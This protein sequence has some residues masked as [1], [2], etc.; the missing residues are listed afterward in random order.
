M[1]SKFV[2]L[3]CLDDMKV[4]KDEVGKKV[5][6]EESQ[7]TLNIVELWGALIFQTLPR[8]E[9]IRYIASTTVLRRQHLNIANPLWQNTV[10]IESD[11]HNMSRK[12]V[13][14][15]LIKGAD[16]TTRQYY[17]ALR[18][19][20]FN[21]QDSSDPVAR[22]YYQTR[23]E[24]PHQNLA[25]VHA[26][27]SAQVL[28]EMLNGREKV[29][30]VASEKDIPVI[31]FGSFRFRLARRKYPEVLTTREVF[32]QVFLEEGSASECYAID[33]TSSDPARRLSLRITGKVNERVFV[34]FV[35]AGGDATAQEINVLV[36]LLDGA[37]KDEILMREWRKP[38]NGLWDI[39]RNE[40]KRKR[41]V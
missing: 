16:E 11:F 3:A 8:N 19:D 21:L 9:L 37:Q 20:F 35:R 13:F 31:C 25:D 7:L 10:K 26:R 15:S 6:A 32:A 30:S 2:V 39:D 22:A 1:L 12:E 38:P 23:R 40:R 24:Q 17:D 18:K 29:V 5:L 27:I 28:Q 33:S 36:D 34:Y 4:V 41:R 14:Y